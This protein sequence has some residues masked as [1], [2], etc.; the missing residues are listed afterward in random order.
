MA[1][2]NKFN[3]F[4]EACAEGV[5]DL[6]SD[7]LAVALSNADPGADAGNLLRTQCPTGPRARRF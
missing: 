2:F 1:D 5:H 7:Q 4:I 3:K 6:G